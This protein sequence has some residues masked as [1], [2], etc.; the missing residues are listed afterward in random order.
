MQ[1]L[2]GGLDPSL[3]HGRYIREK[4]KQIDEFRQR[5]ELQAKQLA[6]M[7]RQAE[8]HAREIARLSAAKQSSPAKGAAEWRSQ[9]EAYFTQFD[10]DTNGTI[11]KK[12]FLRFCVH[13]CRDF[14]GD[15]SMFCNQA[16]MGTVFEHLVGPDSGLSRKKFVAFY[17]QCAA[18]KD[19]RFVIDSVLQPL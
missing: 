10:G 2:L 1:P 7:Q 4:E 11:E 18:A 15:S 6:S 8:E 19:V 5:D 14:D 17:C 16:A 3:S 9:A 13:A 12:D